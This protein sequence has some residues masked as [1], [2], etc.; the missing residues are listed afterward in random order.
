M[1]ANTIRM[2]MESRKPGSRRKV[3]NCGEEEKKMTAK[4]LQRE[5]CRG[6]GIRML[7]VN[8]IDAEMDDLPWKLTPWLTDAGFSSVLITLNSESMKEERDERRRENT[9][10]RVETQFTTAERMCCRVWSRMNWMDNV[11]GLS[12]PWGREPNLVTYRRESRGL[13]DPHLHNGTD[14]FHWSRDGK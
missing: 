9:S 14:Y 5:F 13:G 6:R 1:E 7:E 4:K 11:Y 3:R 8:W 12:F 10:D 2:N